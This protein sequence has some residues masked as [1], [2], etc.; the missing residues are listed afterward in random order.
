MT[1]A[2]RQGERGLGLSPH[3][4]AALLA[5]ALW[6]GCGCCFGV[7]QLTLTLSHPVIPNHPD[8][9]L[10]LLL[11]PPLQ[12]P[13]S[14]IHSP[15]PA[16]LG[17]K[18]AWGAFLQSDSN[19]QMNSAASIIDFECRAKITSFNPK[20]ATDTKRPVSKERHE[21]RAIINESIH[22]TR[23]FCYSFSFH[24]R[25]V[26]PYFEFIS[27]D[28]EK[29]ITVISVPTPTVHT[30]KTGLSKCTSMLWRGQCWWESNPQL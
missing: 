20:I 17:K 22:W 7:W 6:H 16:R 21:K 28:T 8:S 29:L 2:S 25:L 24:G 26:L 12:Q 18:T 5:E 30:L 14:L 9:N 23:F 13:D 3:T 10:L 1:S 4:Q 27:Y 11:H 15:N 19:G